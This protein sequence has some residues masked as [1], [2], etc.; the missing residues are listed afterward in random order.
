MGQFHCAR[1]F[2][3][4]LIPAQDQGLEFFEG[5][6]SWHGDGH[7]ANR[8]LEDL[9]VWPDGLHKLAERG[10]SPDSHYVLDVA[11]FLED[12]TQLMANQHAIFRQ[13]HM[14]YQHGIIPPPEDVI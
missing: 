3:P 2:V 1:G 4:A 9:H 8:M 10:G 5:H 6:E 13:N 14:I 7:C 11:F 12:S